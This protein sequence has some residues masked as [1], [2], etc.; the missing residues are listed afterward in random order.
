VLTRLVAEFDT[1]TVF[2]LFPNKKAERDEMARLVRLVAE[3][4]ENKRLREDR[5]QWA[6][7]QA[8]YSPACEC[9]S[10]DDVMRAARRFYVEAFGQEWDE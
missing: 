1:L 7:E 9:T 4:E 5:R 2:S 6:I 3:E 8:N 10:I